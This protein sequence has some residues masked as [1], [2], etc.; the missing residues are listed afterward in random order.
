[1]QRGNST[2]AMA[3]A[4]LAFS[5]LLVGA[6]AQAQNAPAAAPPP[7][8]P[9]SPPQPPPPP[10]APEPA[11]QPAAA[12]PQ[13]PSAAQPVVPQQPE[14]QFTPPPPPAPPAPP[15]QALPPPP[16]YFY[17][18]YPPVYYRPPPPPWDG[19]VRYTVRASGGVA[20][21]GA[22]YYCGYY[23]SYYVPAYGCGSGF[24]TAQPDINLD[25]DVWVDP[26]MAISFGANVMWG[27]YTP[28]LVGVPPNNV[29]SK[30]WEPHVDVLLAPTYGS[31][32]A[33]GRIRLGFGLYVAEANGQ[34]ATG[35]TVRWNG[36]G[37][38]F[39]LGFGVSLLPK[40]IVGIGM[41]AIFETGWVGSSYVSTVQLLI[42]PELHF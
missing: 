15:Q 21:V 19:K 1:M 7:S 31:N 8:T 20:F 34:N 35:Q 18:Q 23:Y 27:T 12:Q 39:R 24:A 42:G 37:G 28:N 40:S 2:K 5:A 13:P 4:F 29:Y 22:G 30:T 33:K 10:P 3:G 36:V 32:A 17:Y 41:D 26:T 6:A 14:P 38:A 11:A 25:V 16:N 9:Q